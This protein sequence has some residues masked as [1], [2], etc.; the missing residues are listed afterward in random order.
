[1]KRRVARGEPS[2]GGFSKLFREYLIL[3]RDWWLHQAREKQLP[4]VGDWWCWLVLAGRG[5]GKTRMGAEWTIMRAYER[6]GPIAIIGE[7]A[8]DVRD[9]MVELGESSIL[10]VSPKDFVPEYQPSK[11][12]LEWPNGVTATLYSGDRPDQLR[13]PQH[14]TVW[15]DEPAKWYRLNDVWSNMEMGLRFGIDPRCV[16]TTT[17]RPLSLIKEMLEDPRVYVTQGSTYENIDNVSESF[18]HRLRQRYDG[19]RI[20]RQELY[21][22][23]I[24]DLVGALWTREMIDAANWRMKIP[25]LQ[26]VVV[27]V[28]PAASSHEHSDETGLVVAGVDSMGRCFVLD[29]VSGRYT[30]MEWGW[31]AISL[32][33]KWGADRIVCEVNNGGDMVEQT[34]RT[35]WD[36]APIRKVHASRGKHKRAEPVAALYEQGKVYHAGEGLEKVEDQLCGFTMTGYKLDGSPDRADALIWSVTDLMLNEGGTAGVW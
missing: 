15:A 35:I 33:S 21:A 28:D 4:P 9:V 36:A 27:G 18:I 12:R 11:R 22:E 31:A 16:A 5:Y 14:Q 34:I 19:T 25:P 13:G 17:P 8:G 3:K 2:L 7:T 30:P 20:G 10:S 1:M 6:K 26:R 29:D 24:D 23:L 32:C